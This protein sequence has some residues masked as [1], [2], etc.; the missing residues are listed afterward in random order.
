[1]MKLDFSNT[2]EANIHYLRICN[3]LTPYIPN[4]KFENLKF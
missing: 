1:M 2:Y 3:F 4:S